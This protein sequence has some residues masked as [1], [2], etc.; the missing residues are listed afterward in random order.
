MYT[1]VQLIRVREEE[2]AHVVCVC[3]YVCARG[4]ERQIN[5][6]VLERKRVWM[7]YN[8]DKVS[9]SEFFQISINPL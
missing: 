7:R 4:R 2:S 9:Q 1:N 8:R 5:Q 3:V 6:S